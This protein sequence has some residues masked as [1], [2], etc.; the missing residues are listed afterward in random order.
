MR[1][2]AV[3]P[4]V[5][6]TSPPAG[7]ETAPPAPPQP[8]PAYS[9][10]TMGHWVYTTEYG[11]IWVPTD[12]GTVLYSGVPYAYLYTPTNGWTWYVSPWGPGRYHSGQ[13]VRHAWHPRAPRPWV[14]PPAVSVRLE[15]SRR[16]AQ[17]HVDEERRGYRDRDRR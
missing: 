9:M 8:Q 2:D 14:A 11:W 12:A 13:W 15:P 7:V 10:T 3:P 5:Q 17:P 16:V 6:P 4:P 1:E